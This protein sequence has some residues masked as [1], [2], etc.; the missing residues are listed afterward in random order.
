MLPR[1]LFAFES[2]FPVAVAP[3][4][5]PFVVGNEGEEHGSGEGS[6]LW[7][8]VWP[9]SAGVSSGGGVNTVMSILAIFDAAAP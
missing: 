4:L 3:P 5:L 1:S 2:R 8:A 9:Y 7:V 6:S